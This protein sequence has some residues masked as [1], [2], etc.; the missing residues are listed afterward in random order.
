[1]CEYKLHYVCLMYIITFVDNGYSL[2]KSALQLYQIDQNLTLIH[3]YTYPVINTTV[4][5]PQF[6]AYYKCR[7]S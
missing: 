6:I 5:G 2:D 1:M 7:L 4:K 3:S